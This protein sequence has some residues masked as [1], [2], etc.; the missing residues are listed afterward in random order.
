MLFEV[1]VVWSP[2]QGGKE[3]KDYGGAVVVLVKWWY[4]GKTGDN[5]WRW[6]TSFSFIPHHRLNILHVANN[7]V[8]RPEER[9]SDQ[10]VVSCF[11]LFFPAKLSTWT[12]DLSWPQGQHLSWRTLRLPYVE[13]ILCIVILVELMS[14]CPVTANTDCSHCLSVILVNT[15]DHFSISQ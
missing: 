14:S 7:T 12:S 2:G 8:S 6:V 1:Q 10:C 5:N 9:S 3:R 13:S 11:A 15:K 4:K